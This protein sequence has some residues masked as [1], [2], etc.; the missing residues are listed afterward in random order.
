VMRRVG[1]LIALAALTMAVAAGRASAHAT[2]ESTTPVQGSALDV[3]PRQ[4]S[5][6]FSEDVELELGG[7]RVRD[8]AGREVQQGTA[9]HPRGDRRSVAVR[10]RDDVADGAYSTTYRVVSADSHPVSGG[11]VFAVGELG[12]MPALPLDELLAGE[13]SGPVTSVAFAAAHGVQFAAIALAVGG[14]ALLMLVWLPALA[15]VATPSPHWQA[16]SHAFAARW[17]QVLFATA[18]AGLLSAL[19]A[20]P[21]QAAMA[22]GSSLWT[23]FGAADVV[24]STRF[25][26]VYGLGAVAWLTVIALTAPR[27]ARVP[28]LRP[29][30]VG[31]T[32]VAVSRP[33]P[34]SAALAMALG[35]LVFV[36]ALGGHA[37]TEKPVTVMLTA[38]AVHVLA[39]SAWIGGI[40]MI[41]LALPA[42]TRRLAQPNRTEM[43]VAALD[44]FSTLALVSVAALLVGGIVQSV[45]ELEAIGDLL[46]TAYG[47]AVSVK[48]ALLVL[49]LALG[50]LNRLHILPALG[51]AARAGAGPGRPGWTLR[52]A[53]RVELALGAA[54]LAATGALAGYAPP[55]ADPTGPWSGV[56]G[57]G[58]GQAELTIQPAVAGP[59]RMDLLLAGLTAGGQSKEPELTVTASSPSRGIAPIELALRRA[60]PGHYVV[61]RAQLAPAGDWTVDLVARAG[62]FDQFDTSFE[63]EVGE[64]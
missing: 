2:L 44:R 6:R 61:E 59:N 56:S 53:L 37:G 14:V 30:S 29:A 48:I 40:A 19:V 35:W 45:L 42:A 11:F 13:S 10:L 64:R 55:G 36:P 60:G 1:V 57:I 41:L 54:A 28:G 12:S 20:L 47:R 25:G 51:R 32:G 39:A 50:A 9:F 3:A 26:T 46:S 17:R 24:L 58:P 34:W 31:A 4:V 33:T 43:L 21:L 8:A 5:L 23:G 18:V 16:A 62:E 63:V 49:L 38:N 52:R 7:L 15:V 22:E 27:F